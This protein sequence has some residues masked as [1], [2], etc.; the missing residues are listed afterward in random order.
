MNK[1]ERDSGPQGE[2]DIEYPT[3]VS[4]REGG[5]VCGLR[6]VRCPSL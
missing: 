2:A 6:G 3:G 4:R 1:M 5:I